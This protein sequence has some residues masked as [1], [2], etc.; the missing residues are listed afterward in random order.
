MSLAPTRLANSD[1]SFDRVCRSWSQPHRSFACLLLSVRRH[2]PTGAHL[3]S[4]REPVSCWPSLAGRPLP[5]QHLMNGVF[6]SASDHVDETVP[7][8]TALML[9]HEL[10]IRPRPPCPCL[11][12]HSLPTGRVRDVSFLCR[13]R[14]RSLRTSHDS[15]FGAETR[16]ARPCPCC[17][18]IRAK[19]RIRLQLARRA[20]AA[21]AAS[22]AAPVPAM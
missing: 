7:C 19:Y 13:C 14:L 15:S 11:R 20:Q 18:P 2:L 4:A 17:F 6:S 10:R 1:L 22:G 16:S 3:Q 5:V 21:T 9:H 8:P 12:W